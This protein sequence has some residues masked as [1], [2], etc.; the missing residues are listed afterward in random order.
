VLESKKAVPLS[1]NIINLESQLNQTICAVES[2]ILPLQEHLKALR[3]KLNAAIAA[4]KEQRCLERPP[5]LRAVDNVY[6]YI[7]SATSRALSADGGDTNA[8]ITRHSANTLIRHLVEQGILNADSVFMDGG[9]AYNV[10]TCHVA[11]VVGCKAWGVEYVPL[12]AYLAATNFLT[13]LDD[14]DGFGDLINA[15]V[16]YVHTDLYTLNSFGPTTVAYFFDEAFPEALMR[17]IIKSCAN[18]LGLT[19]IISFK[20]SKRPSLHKL[21]AEFGFELLPNA[22]IKVTKI[23][24][25]EN[26]TVYIYKRIR[27][28][29][30]K[31]RCKKVITAALQTE[32]ALALAW[33]DDSTERRKYYQTLKHDVTEVIDERGND[34]A[35]NI[36][37]QAYRQCVTQHVLCLCMRYTITDATDVAG[38]EALVRQGCLTPSVGR[39]T[40]RCLALEALGNIA[41]YTLSRDDDG[42]ARNDRHVV[43]DLNRA[44][45]VSDIKILLNG[46]RL[47]QIIMDWFWMP[48]GFVQERLGRMFGATLQGFTDVMRPGGAIYFPFHMD[49]LNG[50]AYGETHWACCFELSLI[51]STDT[52]SMRGNLLWYATQSIPETTMMN[53]F[54]KAPNQEDLYCLVTRKEVKALLQLTGIVSECLKASHGDIELCRFVKLISKQQ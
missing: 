25:G 20:A 35:G 17:H 42:C 9:A 16:A 39:D 26:N 45:I 13:A 12:R 54:Q 8:E 3:M 30:T 2:A 22:S 10:L 19:H 52:D 51:K 41:V 7:A 50:L 21:F 36:S 49:V 53:C 31:T 33:S 29:G 11:Q 15:K 43:G 28:S 47:D 1:A 18:T 44:K 27:R 6:R 14:P 38:V 24:S 5:E 23:G 46:A 34:C 37:T 48:K 40:A 32:E 4:A